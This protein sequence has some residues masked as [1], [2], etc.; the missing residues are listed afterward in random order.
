MD[1]DLKHPILFFD[2]ACGLC[3]RSVQWALRHDRRGVL[4]FAPLRGQTFAA[5]GTAG[6]QPPKV[7][8]AVL[9]VDGAFLIRSDAVL[10]LLKALGGRWAVLAAAGRIIPRPLRDWAYDRV[11]RRRLAWFGAAEQC[12]AID[13]AAQRVL[14]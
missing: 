10:G 11:A 5:L 12:A 2:G 7:D 1:D 8:S 6:T 13:A 3:T 9:A 4:R 14:P